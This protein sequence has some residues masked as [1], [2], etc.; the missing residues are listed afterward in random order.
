MKLKK[1]ETLWNLGH[2]HRAVSLRS[3]ILENH[4]SRYSSFDES[5]YPPVYSPQFFTNLGHIALFLMHRRLIERDII[6]GGN[7]ILPVATNSPFKVILEIMEI[8]EINVMPINDENPILGVPSLQH[9]V[10]RIDTF[11]TRV[12]FSDIYL[13]M[14]NFFRSEKIVSQAKFHDRYLEKR[15]YF[16]KSYGIE[17]DD[18]VVTLHVR[19]YADRRDV[20]GASAVNFTEAIYYLLKLGYWVVLIGNKNSEPI[21]IQERK[22]LD[23]THYHSFETQLYALTV[24]KFHLGTQS[25]P[26][27]LAHFLGIPVLQTNATA[28]GRNA[29]TASQESLYVPKT[30][31]Q[32][33]RQLSFY[34]VLTSEAGYAESLGIHEGGFKLQENSR[35]EILQATQE[36]I[37]KLEGPVG[38]MKMPYDEQIK[39]IRTECQAVGYGPIS[40]T[41]VSSN[42]K[43][44]N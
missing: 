8:P 24:S 43:W 13:L 16:L 31:H 1:V 25:G 23:L 2:Y 36:M 9:W 44:L 41:F 37:E 15:D 11:K 21:R 22:I 4:Y 3:E 32:G 35:F 6:L 14:E 39:K 27:S 34:E 5:Y 38:G 7:R 26:S 20:R 12:G 19:G 18:K 33:N 40:N 30:V 29:Y 42:P 10:E 28:I 17:Q